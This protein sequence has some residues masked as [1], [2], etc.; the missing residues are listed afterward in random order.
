ML[1]CLGKIVGF[2][3]RVVGPVIRWG[4]RVGIAILALLM[5]FAASDVILRYAF[6]K[7]IQGSFELQE[8]MMGIIV[9]SGIAYC[10]FE[11]G[12]IS[13]DILTNRF[14]QRTQTILNFFHYLIAACL[15]AGVCWRTVIQGLVV[16]SRLL[17]SSV[18]LIPLFPF[19]WVLAFA[20]AIVC[21]A[22]FYSSLESLYKGA[23]KWKH[24]P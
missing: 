5:F 21:L 6:N 24:Q 17:T 9:I 20:S 10:T 3:S 19:Y 4:N 2:L 22:F 1:V 12:H 13:V 7:P 18:L 14:P 16:Q 23:G 11:K 15:F 8:F